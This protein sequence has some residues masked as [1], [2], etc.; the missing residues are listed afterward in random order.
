M[1]KILCIKAFSVASS[2]TAWLLITTLAILMFSLLDDG[3]R[4]C[5]RPLKIAHVYVTA[6]LM[7]LQVTRKDHEVDA[8]QFNV[9][10]EKY[11]QS[12][13]AMFQKL[14]PENP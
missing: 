10:D 11:V 9:F 1:W 7:N 12:R 13:A 2:S 3:P 14:F 8:K 4:E 6:L 5:R